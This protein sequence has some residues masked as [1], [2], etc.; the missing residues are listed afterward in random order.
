MD[1]EEIAKLCERLN[2]DK[3]ESPVLKMN[4]NMYED[5]KEMMEL[6]LVGRVFGNK[7]VNRESLSDVAEQVW[8]T[9]RKVRVESMGV[10]NIFMFHFGC[11]AD[12]QRV[13]S[14]GP[15]N[16]GNQ[17]ISLL[18]PKEVGLVSSMDFTKVSFWIQFHNVP[19]VCR[20][21]KCARL[22][23]EVIGPVMDTDTEGPTK[24]ARVI[25]DVTKPRGLRVFTDNDSDAVSIP[26]QY[27]Y[28]P[29]FCFG[30]RIIG[31]KLRE[32]PE[33]E[34]LV[35]TGRPRVNRYGDWLKAFNLKQ[36]RKE[37]RERKG[38]SQWSDS[39]TSSGKS[40]DNG[41]DNWSE[42]FDTIEATMNSEE[43][44]GRLA[45]MK[46][47]EHKI[48]CNDQAADDSVGTGA[49]ALKRKDD[50]QDSS[51]IKSLTRGKEKWVMLE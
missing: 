39:N 41:D 5:G 2:L 33:K 38:K 37:R 49:V 40:S 12:R 15:W 27:E 42:G 10:T 32:C 30:C 1:P 45:V 20:S 31:H 9:S 16:F 51:V 35:S 44:I 24:R 17:L 26:I 6:C 13:I 14:G 11:K 19:I 50:I 3:H 34:G 28:L 23:G 21:D 29:E 4:P 47:R 22:W 46:A 48:F 8:C 7:I 18:K 36:W 43:E 25:I